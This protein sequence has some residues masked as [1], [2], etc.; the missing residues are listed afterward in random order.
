MQAAVEAAARAVE[1]AGGKVSE[2]QLPA[3][4]EDAFLAH[5]TIQNSVRPTWRESMTCSARRLDRASRSDMP[6]RTV[7]ISAR[8]CRFVSLIVLN[9]GT[10][11]VVGDVY[12]SRRVRFGPVPPGARP[13]PHG[14]HHHHGDGG[15]PTGWL[16][17]RVVH[18][19]VAR[20]PAGGF[21]FSIRPRRTAVFRARPRTDPAGRRVGRRRRRA[22]GETH[23]TRA[24][25]D[26]VGRRESMPRLAVRT[27][28]G[29]GRDS[30]PGTPANRRA[31]CE[32]AS[33][34]RFPATGRSDRYRAMLA[35]W[36]GRWDREVGADLF[37]SP[38]G[39]V[40]IRAFQRQVHRGQ[41][42]HRR[43]NCCR[44]PG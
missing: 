10:A 7:R 38:A 18:L 28:V 34:G 22:S 21:P 8:I 16:H 32:I 2:S 3:I 29:Q 20:S 26:P 12:L 31:F 13:L 33:G 15:R 36:N 1:H 37:P 6:A 9:L 43:P 44:T 14:G 5:G 24:R 17:D 23:S 39:G 11:T 40:V 4:F 27:D 35:M 19:G 25:R 42:E 30:C 41:R